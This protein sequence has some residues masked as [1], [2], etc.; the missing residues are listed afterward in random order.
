MV[1]SSAPQRQ[2]Q[3]GW[4]FQLGMFLVVIISSCCVLPSRALSSSTSSS[5]SSRTGTR[6]RTRS[7]TKA[8]TNR[9]APVAFKPID[10]SP[11]EALK[12]SSASA[13]PSSPTPITRKRSESTNQSERWEG[14]FQELLA[15]KE[16]YGHSNVPQYPTKA[17]PENHRVLA[18]FCR[19]CRTQYNYHH[20]ADKQHLS[21]LTDDRIQSLEDI[22]FCWNTREATWQC[23]WNELNAF[24]NIF[25]HSN[26][27]ARWLPKPGLGAWVSSQSA[28]FC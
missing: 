18:T 28:H 15:F 24:K 17:I 13:P 21:F 8:A 1:T 25:G 27:P 5:T 22:G 7:S 23:R 12:S 10:D 14:R 2:R 3:F 9:N 6:T 16:R 26:V 11:I 19:N 4:T 20:D